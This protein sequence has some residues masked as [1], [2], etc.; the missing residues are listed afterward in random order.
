MPIRSPRRLPRLL[1]LRL[2]Q[3]L[4]RGAAALWPSAAAKFHA[5]MF[6]VLA[7]EEVPWEGLR[8]V[9]VDER[10]APLGHTDRNL[11]VLREALLKYVPLREEQI[12]AMPVESPDLGERHLRRLGKVAAL[13]A[14]Q[15]ASSCTS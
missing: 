3:P 2:G 14:E 15:N 6:R 1:L 9:Q 5:K 12:H 7:R 11:T 13:E 4:P 10:V 8:V